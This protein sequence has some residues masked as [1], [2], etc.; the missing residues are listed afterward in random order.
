MKI[1]QN[2]S[3]LASMQRINSASVDP[4]GLSISEQLKSAGAGL[5]QAVD[6]TKDAINLSNVAD[7]SLDGIGEQLGRMKELAVQAS[8]GILSNDDKSVIQEEINQIKQEISDVAKNTQFN[9]IK[10]LDGSFQDVNIANTGTAQGTKMNIANTS[11]ETLGIADFDVT[12]EGFNIED[13]D[14]AISKV[15]SARGD[16]GAQTNRFESSVRSN[17]ITREN[18]IASQ[19]RIADLDIGAAVT[20]LKQNEIMEQYKL[21]IQKQQMQQQGNALNLLL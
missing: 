21:S 7:G 17:E 13:I 4:A 2:Y 18:T 1:D 10:L 5:E 11:L 8:N 9:G 19:S 20:Q 6:N 12:V 16:I 3:Q 15:T 14:N